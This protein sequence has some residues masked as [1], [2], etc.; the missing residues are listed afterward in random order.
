MRGDT[1]AGLEMFT[2]I[3]PPLVHEEG[4]P[5]ARPPCSARPEDF[6]PSSLRFQGVYACGRWIVRADPEA[7]L[8]MFTGMQPPLAPEVALSILTSEAPSLCAPYLQAALASSTAAPEVFHTELALIYLRSAL[9]Q[10]KPGVHRE[11]QS[12]GIL[13]PADANLIKFPITKH[14]T[15]K[16]ITLSLLIQLA[17]RVTTMRV[18]RREFERS[19]SGLGSPLFYM[20]LYCR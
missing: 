9:E 19:V 18:Q 17:F 1:E 6:F 2:A 13:F 12:P 16:S 11:Q 4:L 14:A 7:G 20:R 5:S 10:H 8:E 15:M 3:Q